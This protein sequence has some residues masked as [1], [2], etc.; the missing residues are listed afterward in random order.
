MSLFINT[1]Y[2]VKIYRITFR[3]YINGSRN[4]V[5]NH[6]STNPCEKDSYIELEKN[7]SILVRENEI[8]FYKQ[9]GDGIDTMEFVGLLYPERNKVQN[10]PFTLSID[11]NSIA[12]MPY[13]T[14]DDKGNIKVV[15]NNINTDTLLKFKDDNDYKEKIVYTGDIYLKE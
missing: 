8:D 1:D 7:G 12:R 5:S 10:K 9:F 13:V 6:N 4:T 11:D 3:Q 14:Q 2:P 15:P